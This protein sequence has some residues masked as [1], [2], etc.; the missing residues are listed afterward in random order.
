MSQQS[1]PSIT[2][3]KKIITD[4]AQ[5]CSTVDEGNLYFAATQLESALDEARRDKAETLKRLRARVVGYS[6]S[7][8]V[9]RVIDGEIQKADPSYKP[10]YSARARSKVVI[11]RNELVEELRVD[12]ATANA[13]LDKALKLASHKFDCKYLGPGHECSCSFNGLR[14]EIEQHRGGKL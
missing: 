10:N 9:F 8:N 7:R 4:Y 3:A 11:E 1:K 12:L 2:E 6:A 14:K 13:L 5:K